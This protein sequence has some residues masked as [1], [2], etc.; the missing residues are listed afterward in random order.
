MSRVS[1]ASLGSH[2][3][4]GIP[5]PISVPRAGSAVGEIGVSVV[6]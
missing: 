6:T 2:V 3:F 4:V 5:I 1:L